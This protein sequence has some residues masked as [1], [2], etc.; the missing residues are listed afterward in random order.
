[1]IYSSVM[2]HLEVYVLIFDQ[3][4]LKGYL[5]LGSGRLNPKGIRKTYP[6]SY[7]AFI[8]AADIKVKE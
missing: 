6:R 1:L 5:T 2:Y 4:T 3:N 8:K 7:H